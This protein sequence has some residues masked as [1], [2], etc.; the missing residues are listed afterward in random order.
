MD[1]LEAKNITPTQ[2]QVEAMGFSMSQWMNLSEEIKEQ[3]LN[4]V[5]KNLAKEDSEAI[6]PKSRSRKSK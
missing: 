6:K 5:E 4:T 1:T 3:Y 2:D